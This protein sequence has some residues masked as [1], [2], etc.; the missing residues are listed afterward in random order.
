MDKE[1]DSAPIKEKVNYAVPIGIVSVV[2]LLIFGIYTYSKY[3]PPS[4]NDEV[5]ELGIT[6]MEIADDYIDGRMNSDVASSKLNHIKDALE[7]YDDTDAT[8]FGT[9]IF[10]L[11]ISIGSSESKYSSENSKDVI[12]SRNDLADQLHKKKR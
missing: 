6:A 8:I 3:A 10:L 4:M 11:D 5:Y 2:L 1:P 9:T 7:E 12:D